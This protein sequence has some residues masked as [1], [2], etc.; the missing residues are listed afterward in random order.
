M[1]MQRQHVRVR[2]LEERKALLHTFYHEFQDQQKLSSIMADD[3]TMSE[4]GGSKTYSKRDYLGIFGAV[5][6]AIPDFK[7]GAAT[8]GET[9]KDGFA[10]VTVTATGHHTGAPLQLPNLEPVPASGK[11]FCLAEEVQKVKVNGNKIQQIVV[12]PNK[13]AGPRALYQVLGGQLPVKSSA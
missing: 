9:D 7:W 1:G 4:D 3:F 13:G 8:N 12:L 6:A 5:L 11:H 2:S 10:I